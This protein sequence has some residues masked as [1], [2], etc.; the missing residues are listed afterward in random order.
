M[1]AILITGSEGFVGS[2]L[3]DALQDDSY[4]IIR[5]CYPLLTTKNP[6]CVPLD[7]TNCEKTMDVIKNSNPDIIIHLAAISSVSKSFRD[8]LLTYN[9]NVLGT[10]NV[11]EAAKSIKK[12]VKFIY[13]STCEVY[14]GG[15]DIKETTGITLVNP[16]A[17]SKYAAELICTSYSIGLNIECVILRSF[18][19]TGPGQSADFVLPTIARQI[20]DIEKGKKPRE[21]RLGNLEA[22]REF[23]NV[24]DIVKAYKLA[25]EKCVT[26]AIYNI[27][28]GKGYSIKQSIDEFQKYAAVEFKVISDTARKRKTDIPVLVGNGEK[29]T[30][31]TGWKPQVSF[32]KT[33]EELLE[34][35]RA[36]GA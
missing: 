30:R 4:N 11:L 10:V 22:V 28:S 6:E 1:K 19:H 35:W 7:I 27:S 36:Q 5:T 32:S 20:V 17:V 3:V 24:L 9:S 2:H 21:V 34:Y 16:Y 33:I 31:Q 18:T 25:I 26:G 15:T 12:P 8:P 13:I 23:M 14:G 29:F